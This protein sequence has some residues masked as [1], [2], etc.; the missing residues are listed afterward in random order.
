MRRSSSILIYIDVEK[1][2]D[3]GLKFYLSANSV[4][5]TDGDEDGFIRPQFFSRVEATNGKPVPGWKPVVG[6]TS[7]GPEI[8]SPGQPSAAAPSS[9]KEPESVDDVQE[10]AE[11]LKI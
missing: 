5:L 2:L 10:K 6:P 9:S 8:L 11:A 1:A 4:V 7:T 3:A